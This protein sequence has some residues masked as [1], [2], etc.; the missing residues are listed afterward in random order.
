MS[1]NFN[2]VPHKP[3]IETLRNIFPGLFILSNLSSSYKKT[4]VFRK[5]NINKTGTKSSFILKSTRGRFIINN[6]EV[7]T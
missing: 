6:A 4:N 7:S 5:L 3:K 2:K 1:G